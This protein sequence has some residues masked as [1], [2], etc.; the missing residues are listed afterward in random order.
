MPYEG[1]ATV[2]AFLMAL[3]SAVLLVGVTDR[4]TANRQAIGR[5]VILLISGPT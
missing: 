1:Q 5:G 4:G 3:A 2:G